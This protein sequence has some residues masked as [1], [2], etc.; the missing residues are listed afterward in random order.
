MHARYCADGAVWAVMVVDSR[1]RHRPRCSSSDRQLPSAVI[2]NVRTELIVPFVVSSATT[3]SWARV[4]LA[5]G[6]ARR[7]LAIAFVSTTRSAWVL[8]WRSY[9]VG[10]Q[11]SSA[12][13]AMSRARAKVHRW[14]ISSSAATRSFSA[15]VPGEHCRS[16][17]TALFRHR[18]HA[19]Y[20][21]MHNGWLRVRSNPYSIISDV[22][23]VSVLGTDRY[24]SWSCA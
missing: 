9:F 24:M 22:P 13:M 21:Q 2:D 16:R 6:L 10:K 14:P 8:H 4:A 18:C 12:S 17:S 7:H 1:R 20:K 11:L 19:N 5:W 3:S 15:P 23:L